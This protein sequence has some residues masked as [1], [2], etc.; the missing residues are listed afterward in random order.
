M[1]YE[2][3]S[4]TQEATAT[5]EQRGSL[6]WLAL[7]ALAKEPEA[8]RPELG[9]HTKASTPKWVTDHQFGSLK[10]EATSAVTVL[11]AAS[12]PAHHRLGSLRKTFPHWFWFLIA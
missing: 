11:Q 5:S 9:R 6:P 4:R 1:D 3:G 12:I 2:G 10:M 7:S 8:L